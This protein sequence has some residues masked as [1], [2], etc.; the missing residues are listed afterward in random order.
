M[1]GH[2]RCWRDVASWVQEIRPGPMRSGPVLNLDADV[3]RMVPRGRIELPTPRFSVG[4]SR[5]TQAEQRG[6]HWA[7]RKETG[8]GRTQMAPLGRLPV[9]LRSS[10]PRGRS[11][12]NASN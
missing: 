1:L 4:R 8:T 11:V 10:K 5:R 6:K 9:I 12:G 3:E 2:E 7:N